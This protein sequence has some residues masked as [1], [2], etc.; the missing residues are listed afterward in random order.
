MPRSPES[1]LQHL[2][3]TSVMTLSSQRLEHKISSSLSFEAII[4]AEEAGEIQADEDDINW[5]KHEF[6]T[7]RPGLL[8][9]RTRELMV[10]YLLPSFFRALSHHLTGVCVAAETNYQWNC[11]SISFQMTFCLPSSQFFLTSPLSSLKNFSFLVLNFDPSFV[12]S[13]SFF[14]FFPDHFSLWK[15]FSQSVSVQFDS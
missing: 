5:L 4:A 11:C 14:F 9:Q 3:V 6:D 12:D 2:A 7:M 1:R 15:P 13:R 10:H 8:V